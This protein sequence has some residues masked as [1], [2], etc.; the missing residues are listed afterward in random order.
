[1]SA[2]FPDV[3]DSKGYGAAG[4]VAFKTVVAVAAL[5]GLVATLGFITYLRKNRTMMLNH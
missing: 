5:A 2:F 4:Y 3:V 1:M